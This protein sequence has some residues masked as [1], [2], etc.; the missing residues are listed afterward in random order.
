MGIVPDTW[1]VSVTCPSRVDTWFCNSWFLWATD[2]CEGSKWGRISPAIEWW[3][4]QTRGTCPACVYTWFTRDFLTSDPFEL[5]T[6]VRGQNG[7]EFHQESNGH[8]VRYVTRVRH[9]LTR[10]LHTIWNSWSL[11]ATY[12]CERSK[13]GIISLGIQLAWCQTHGTYMSIMCLMCVS[14]L[15]WFSVQCFW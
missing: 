10:N 1:H 6:S 5:Q 14:F 4:V 3:V 9:V 15:V 12:K 13:C 8:G 2:K 7:V 11:R